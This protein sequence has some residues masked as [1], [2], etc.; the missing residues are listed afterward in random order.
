MIHLKHD[1]K[2]WNIILLRKFKLSVNFY[3]EGMIWYIEICLRFWIFFGLFIKWCWILNWNDGILKKNQTFRAFKKRSMDFSDFWWLSKRRKFL[4]KS[5]NLW[6]C[7]FR[8]SQIIKI[9][10]LDFPLILTRRME[11][12]EWFSHHVNCNVKKIQFFLQK[13]SSVIF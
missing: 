13:G 2:I 3:A 8:V 4:K 6:N 1:I 5:K 11:I 10:S 12:L 7:P 9:Y